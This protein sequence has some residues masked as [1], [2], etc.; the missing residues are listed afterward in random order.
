MTDP[1]PPLE[2]RGDLPEQGDG[3]AQ[4]PDG[5]TL[6]GL[7]GVVVNES[8]NAIFLKD[9]DGRFLYANQA[10]A[11]LYGTTP[12]ALLG[13]TSAV[14]NRNAEQVALFNRNAQDIMRRFQPEVVFEDSTN[15]RTGEVRHFQAFKRPLRDAQGR[16]QILVIANDIT[17]LVKARSL[18]EFAEQDLRHVQQVIGEGVWDWDLSTD[19]LRHNRRWAEMLGLDPDVTVRTMDEYTKCVHPEDADS[20]LAS[21]DVCLLLARPYHHEY[22]VCRPDG[23]VAWLLDRGDVVERDA[24]GAARRMVGSFADITTRK[25]AEQ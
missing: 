22:R 8:R 5:E 6:A 18:A 15:A 24:Q 4:F 11:D 21:L 12:S 20:H 13:K 14:F 3:C 9:W 17:D 19:R 23:S 25:F 10:V 16:L 7:F 1:V 2:P